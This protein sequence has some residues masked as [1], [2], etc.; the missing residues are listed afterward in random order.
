MTLSKITL[1]TK[2]AILIVVTMVALPSIR[3][4]YAKEAEKPAGEFSGTMTMV[5]DYS[6]RGISQ[7]DS[8][9][10][11]QG[12]FDYAHQS[13]LYAGIWGSNVDFN[14][15]GVTSLETDIYAGFKFPLA[16][17]N[18]DV[19]GIAY[20][21]PGQNQ[22]VNHYNFYEGKVAAN[23]DF[24]FVNTTAQINY[25]PNHFGSTLGGSGNAIYLNLS[26]IVPIEK[27]GLNLI[28]AVGH[29]WME[30]N[31]HFGV[32]DYADWNLGLGY[33]W[34]G[35]DFALKYVDTNIG[36]SACVSGLNWCDARAVFSVSRAF[37]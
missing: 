15:G 12:S 20:I 3:F 13:G 28:A 16:G 35:F 18:M 23:K 5:S 4:A 11:L 19:G 31:T 25:S 32:P 37:K 2:F 30:K 9:P 29:Q 14:D 10:A 6:L 27:T 24:G 26:G 33:S 17:M 21:Y 34:Q 7:N 8:H 22:G 1:K 36:K